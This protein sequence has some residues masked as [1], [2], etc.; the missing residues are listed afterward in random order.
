[1]NVEILWPLVAPFLSALIITVLFVPLT[2]KLAFKY[3]LVDDPKKRPHPAHIQQRVVPRAGGLP[4]YLG[5][6]ITALSFLPLT[7]ALVG[8]I[9]GSTIL[10]VMGLAFTLIFAMMLL[11]RTRAA[12]LQMRIRR[13]RMAP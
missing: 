3:G 12:I 4:I 10:L 2:I 11:K 8:M 5:I 1:M 9:V 6:S 7:Q 13:L